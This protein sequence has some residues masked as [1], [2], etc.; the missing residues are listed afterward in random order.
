M[1]VTLHA[2]TNVFVCVYI[3]A[4]AKQIAKSTAL[5]SLTFIGKFIFLILYAIEKISICEIT[6]LQI[7]LFIAHIIFAS[8]QIAQS[9][10]DLWCLM[11]SVSFQMET[12]VFYDGRLICLLTKT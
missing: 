9:Y 12:D 5:S 7:V 6:F 1:S 4:P 3:K 2:C 8:V 11:T 10:P